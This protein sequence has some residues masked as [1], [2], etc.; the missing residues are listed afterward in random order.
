M[1]LAP[2]LEIVPG[3]TVPEVGTIRGAGTI[4]PAEML[5]FEIVPASRSPTET[6]VFVRDEYPPSP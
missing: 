4:K 1:Q 3:V 5:G 6:G 2:K